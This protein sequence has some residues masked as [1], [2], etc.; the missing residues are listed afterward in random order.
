VAGPE[1]RAMSTTTVPAP[2]TNR[3]LALTDTG[4]AV[5]A[6]YRLVHALAVLDAVTRAKVLAL[7]AEEVAATDLPF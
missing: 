6:A 4:Q 7:V 1:G 3:V 2:E 5:R